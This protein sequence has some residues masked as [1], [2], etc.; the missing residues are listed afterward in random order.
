MKTMSLCG[1]WKLFGRSQTEKNEKTLTLEATVPGMVQLDLSAA[2]YLPKDLYMGENI[3]A[4]EQFEDHEWFYETEFLSPRERKNVFLV[5][6]GVDTIADYYLNGKKIGSSDNMFIT[7]EFS[8]GEY[9]KDGSNTLTVHILSPT[10]AA[11][12]YS[13]DIS[14]IDVSWRDTPVDTA[15]RRA[16]HSYGWDIMPRAVT[17]GIW[18]EVLLEVRDDVYFTQL[19]VHADGVHKP[20]FSYETASARGD[21]HGIEIELVGSLGDSSFTHRFVAPNKAG[22]TEFDIPDAKLWW[23]LGYGEPNV[24]DLWARIY[25]DGKLIHT[26]KTQFGI[27]KVELDRSDTTDGLNGRF[28]FLINGVEVMCRGSNWVPLDAFHSRDASRYERALS[29]VKDIGCNILRCWGG[30]VYEDHAF[31]DF[32]DRNGVMVWQDFAMACNSYPKNGEFLEKLHAEASS[33]IRELRHHPSIILWSGDNE[34]DSM[35]ASFGQRPSMNKITRE[36]LPDAVYRNDVGRP[37][38][39]SSPYISDAAFDSDRR[40]WQNIPENHLWGARDYFKSDY[41]K[42]SNAHFVSEIGYHGCPSLESIKKFITPERVWPYRNNPEWILHSSDQRGNDGRV[43]LMEKQVRQLFGDVPDDAELYVAASQISQA[44]AKKF[45]IEHMRIGRPVKSGI[46]W[47]N[48]LDG[49]PQMSDAVVDYYF[50][51]KLAYYYIK[52]SQAPFAVAMDEIKSWKSGLFALNDTLDDVNGTVTVKDA[53]TESLIY[54]GTFLAPKNSSTMIASIPIFYS[55]HKMLIIDFA[56]DDGRRGRN[57]YLCGYPPFDLKKYI[58][59]IERYGL[60]R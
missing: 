45:F 7:H 17:S 50:E 22:K 43:M 46:I 39:A 34:V 33:V 41:Y 29:L 19:F 3:K 35:C 38:L 54:S 31:F 10:V 11:N 59:W 9:L 40:G 25:R 16:P 47:W 48:L 32:C 27:R 30:N 8:V 44:E 55:E 42:N 13:Y 14:S 20:R 37:Y 15:I 49:W 24:Y 26:K 18:R 52:R 36:V 21:F 6:R 2:G 51:K 12:E 4:A 53:E 58:E 57:H 1:K 23:P 5:F 28:R 60:D 56:L